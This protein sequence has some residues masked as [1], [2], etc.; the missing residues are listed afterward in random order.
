MGLSLLWPL[1]LRSTGSGCAGSAPMAHGPS[2]S[3]ACG[4]FPDWGTNSCPLHR[5]ADSKPLRHQGSPPAYNLSCPNNSA[6]YPI[7]HLAAHVSFQPPEYWPHLMP[8]KLGASPGTQAL[9]SLQ[10]L[11]MWAREMTVA[12]TYQGSPRADVSSISTDTQRRSRWK[13]AP[14]CR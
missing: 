4:I 11:S 9:L 1:L 10:R 6:L 13:P 8:R 2:C 14:F 5:Q 3:A 7:P 12:E